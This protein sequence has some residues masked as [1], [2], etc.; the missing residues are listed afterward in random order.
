MRTTI[1]ALLLALCISCYS[2]GPAPIDTAR[3]DLGQIM[4][5][6][7]LSPDGTAGDL[8]YEAGNDKNISFILKA[9]GAGI[10]STTLFMNED[11]NIERKAMYI[12]GG[13]MIAVGIT[14]DIRGNTK[15]RRSGEKL[16]ELE[17]QMKSL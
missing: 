3:K 10:L 15:I 7:S 11:A 14:L 17:R 5:E 1:T 16:R 12:W 6:Y 2:Q 13:A 4:R 8:L 9:V